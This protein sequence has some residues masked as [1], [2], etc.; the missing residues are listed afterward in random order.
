MIQGLEGSPGLKKIAWPLEPSD[1]RTH[2]ILPQTK[3]TVYFKNFCNSDSGEQ[4]LGGGGREV[5]MDVQETET[6]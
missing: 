5:G 2:S 1:P 6:R 3:L 4:L